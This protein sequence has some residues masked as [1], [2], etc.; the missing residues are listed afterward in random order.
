MVSIPEAI[1]SGTPILTNTQPASVEYIRANG[2][3]IVKDNWDEYDLKK[4]VDENPDYVQNC[5][6]YRDKLTNTHAARTFL[7][8]Y[9][10]EN[11]SAGY[12]RYIA[13]SGLGGVGRLELCVEYATH[14]QADR[15]LWK[16]TNR[17]RIISPNQ[18]D[19]ARTIS[20]YR[21]YGNRRTRAYKRYKIQPELQ[22]MA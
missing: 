9:I 18:Y 4:I 2:L 19:A 20:E 3:G 11:N 15:T 21:L 6:A 14:E 5:I 13:I 22:K 12:I 8:I 16:R 17:N 1:V 10:Y 7:N